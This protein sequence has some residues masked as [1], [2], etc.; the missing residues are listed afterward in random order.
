[1]SKLKF[2]YTRPKPKKKPI[3]RRIITKAHALY[4]V[5][6]DKNDRRRSPEEIKT[7]TQKGVNND[8]DKD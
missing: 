2:N 3:V 6:F 4:S 1:M 8:K 5:L 7:L